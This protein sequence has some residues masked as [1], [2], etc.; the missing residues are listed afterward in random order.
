MLLPS[1]LETKKPLVQAFGILHFHTAPSSLISQPD[2]V[3]AHG[4]G[5]IPVG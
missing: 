1:R 4:K 2:H 5:D 3:A